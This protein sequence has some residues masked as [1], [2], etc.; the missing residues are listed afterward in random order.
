MPRAERLPRT[1]SPRTDIPF[2]FDSY[3]SLAQELGEM[4][5]LAAALAIATRHFIDD[6]IASGHP[7]NYALD[8]AMANS[9]ATRFVDFDG[10]T[11]H[12]CQLL[13]VGTYQQAE[14]FLDNF[15]AEQ[16]AMGRTWRP[17][18][19][20]ETRLHHALDCLPGEFSVNLTKVGKERYE[21]HDYYRRIRNGFVHSSIDRRNL[22][23]HYD[24]VVVHR[25][26]VRDE[27]NLLAPNLFGQ[28]TFHDHLLF[29]RVTKYLAT[30]LCRLG[31]PDR[32]KELAL[33][34]A[35]PDAHQIEPITRFS[36][37]RDSDDSMRRAIRAWFKSRHN[38]QTALRPDLEDYLMQWVRSL[39]TKKQRRDMN[40]I[41]FVEYARQSATEL[42]DDA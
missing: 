14:A 13:I 40:G 25:E 24:R 28:L 38:F 12:L 20:G 2:L 18:M 23:D 11:P 21:V 42:A 33:I 39:P 27:Y 15:R 34:L 3:R 16:R 4:D 7:Q 19:D 31:P 32:G 30:D 1:R 17:R 6:A 22:D 8:L 35:E 29:T 37:R 10:L 36:Q 26:L 5:G 9:V 41:K